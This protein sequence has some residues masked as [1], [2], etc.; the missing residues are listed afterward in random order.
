MRYCHQDHIFSPSGLGTAEM[1]RYMGEE[2]HGNSTSE[3]TS[4]NTRLEKGS[5]YTHSPGLKSFLCDTH[6]AG[7]TELSSNILEKQKCV[8]RVECNA[9]VGPGINANV[10]R[11][12][13]D[14]PWAS[15]QTRSSLPGNLPENVTNCPATHPGTYL[16]KGTWLWLVSVLIISKAWLITLRVSVA[17]CPGRGSELCRKRNQSRGNFPSGSHPSRL[18]VVQ[19]LSCVQL[20]ETPWTTARQAS[21]SFTISQGLLRFMSIES[22][23][24]S[25]HL[26]LCHPLLLPSIVPSIKL[27]FNESILQLR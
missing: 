2:Q 4:W 17:Q 11:H 19:L 5:L 6:I 26:I 25:N 24:P 23:M 9:T 7:S 13:Q 22:V 15:Q 12:L 8:A 1:P 3:E 20:S 14:Q 16:G 21:L 18:V 27:F 10:V